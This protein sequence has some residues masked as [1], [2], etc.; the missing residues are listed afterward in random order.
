MAIKGFI[1]NPFDGYTIE[2]LPDQMEDNK[3]ALPKE[4]AYDCGGKGKAEI[5][6]VKIIIPSPP[7]KSDT[8]YRKQC[9]AGAG[10]NR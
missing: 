8:V 9:R 7:K 4:L 1:G 2:P 5:K 10:I 6:E 3:I